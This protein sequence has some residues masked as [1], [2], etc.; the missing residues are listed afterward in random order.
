MCSADDRRNDIIEFVVGKYYVQK[1][2]LS[3]KSNEKKP[4]EK[5]QWT[6]CKNR[7]REYIANADNNS[8]SFF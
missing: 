5:V 3:N 6:M 8:L 2:N 1:S 4:L 7:Y